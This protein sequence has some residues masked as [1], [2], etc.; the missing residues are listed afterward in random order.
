MALAKDIALWATIR[1]DYLST[2]MSYSK[3]AKKH[4]VPHHSL[5]YLQGRVLKNRDLTLCRGQQYDSSA[6]SHTYTCGDIGVEE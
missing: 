5:L 3:L 1:A 2:G 6:V 4:G